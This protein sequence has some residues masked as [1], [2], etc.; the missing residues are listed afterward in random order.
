MY[1]NL[2]SKYGIILKNDVS[3]EFKDPNPNGGPIQNSGQK[4]G[5]STATMAPTPSPSSTTNNKRKRNTASPSSSAARVSAKKQQKSSVLLP[6]E[7]VGDDDDADRATVVHPMAPNNGPATP[8]TLARVDKDGQQ[9]ALVLDNGGDT[10]KY[11]WA[12]TSTTTTT[13]NGQS[14]HPVPRFMPNVTARLPQQWTVLVGDEIYTSVSNP[15]SCIAVTRSTER[16][17]ITNLGNQIQVWKRILDVVGVVVSWKKD[18]PASVAFGWS[19]KSN[20]PNSG[21]GG[22]ETDKPIVASKNCNVLIG[23]APYTPRSILDQILTIWLD[24][25]GFQGAGFCV[26]PAAA[27]IYRP[28]A[29]IRRT[30]EEQMPSSLSMTEVIPIACV[31][32]LGWSAIQIVP[33]YKDKVIGNGTI[34]RL[35]FGAR[36]LINIWKYTASYRQ[37]NLMDNAEWVLRD[38][39]EQTALVST[40]FNSDMNIARRM[41][42]GRRP[43]DCEYVLPD[44]SKSNA[45]IVRIPEAVQKEIEKGKTVDPTTENEDEDDD[46]YDEEND[47]DYN[48]IDMVVDGG[49]EDID[50]D[51][52]LV[53]SSGDDDDEDSPEEIRKQLLL[54]READRRRMDLEAQQQ[55][56]LNVSTERFA[57]PEAL[58]RPS[59]VGFPMDWAN[60]PQAIVQVISACPK[61]Y[62]AGLYQSVQLTGGLSQLPNLSSRLQEELRSL[63]PSQYDVC[64]PTCDSISSSPAS[65]AWQGAARIALHVPFAEWGVTREEWNASSGRGAWKKL[66]NKK[67]GYLV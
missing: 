66:V 30:Q 11:G 28:I 41:P 38:L 10:V 59:D 14:T 42:A 64:V 56:V 3:L 16:G 19:T 26:S 7:H 46:D 36:H 27:A 58:F 20:K 18:N 24:D 12:T 4:T 45:G 60:L 55:Q 34:R 21:G 54:Q 57:I 50:D 5:R 17:I 43:Y 22:G 9:H 44:Y 63:V 53:G 23:I 67:S 61:I 29:P 62:R 47:E 1:N 33:V 65:Q 39:F 48:E 25:F 32:D 49:G 2:K 31:V 37:W 6:L 51:E 40:Q 15:N 8:P 52:A 35:P 13:T